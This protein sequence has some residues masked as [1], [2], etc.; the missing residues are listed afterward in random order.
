MRGVG[1]QVKKL[2]AASQN[3]QVTDN[4][5]SSD[6]G[7]KKTQRN[8]DLDGE[9]RSQT[10][11]SQR[12][13]ED[14]KDKL[15]TAKSQSARKRDI[16]KQKAGERDLGMKGTRITVQ[17]L[18]SLVKKQDQA[19]KERI[20]KNP[21]LLGGAKETEESMMQTSRSHNVSKN[22]VSTTENKE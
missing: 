14:N 18:V 7:G 3:L 17:Q 22:E 9:I 11:N 10:P 2:D 5:D 4:D 8:S 16:S 19:Y 15:N 20:K 6:Q 21:S 13:S 12:S 1:L